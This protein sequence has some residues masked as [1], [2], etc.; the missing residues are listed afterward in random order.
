M[1]PKGEHAVV[2]GA[3]MGGLLA[4][5]ALSDHFEQVTLLERDPFPKPGENRGGVPQGQHAHALLSSGREVMEGFFP[6]LTLELVSQGAALGDAVLHVVRV[7]GGHRYPRFKSG[8]QGL[9]LSRPLLEAEV[10]RRLL[11][12][13]NVRAIERCKVLG[14]VTTPD[15]ATVTGVRMVYQEDGAEAVL[16]ADL[17]VDASGRGSRS[18]AWLEAMGY[19]RPPVEQVQ[20]NVGYATCIYRRKPGY[21][22]G[23][24]TFGI[25]P[26]PPNRRMGV[27]VTMEQDR[28]MV[29]LVGFL[30]DHPPTDPAGFVEFAKTLPAPDLYQAIRDAEPL[31]QPLPGK[32]PASVRHHY[33]R[34]ERFPQGYLVFGD[35][36]CSFNPTY[37]QGMSV[38]ALEAV[39]LQ[40]CLQEGTGGLAQRFFKR[41]NRIIEIPW[42]I[43]VGGDLRFAQVEGKRGPMRRLINWYL[44]KFHFA[45]QADP[46]LVGAFGRVANL[47]ASPKSLLHPKFALRVLRGNLFPAK[48]LAGARVRT[49]KKSVGRAG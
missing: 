2:I 30:G 3:S 47:K 14:L 26:A 33:Q 35:A 20:V 17:V 5:R 36:L 27:M 1:K 9:S 18:P 40:A 25:T 29:S 13:P 43:A 22:E 48:A 16:N 19:G 10:R 21:A 4:A 41:V 37:G 49:P 24:L 7:I 42:S 15:R 23:A 31:S 11:A 28:W 45:A 6:G 12:L 8:V 32:F 34:L 46:R 44:D 38:A 39:A